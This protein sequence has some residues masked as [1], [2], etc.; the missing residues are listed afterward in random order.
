MPLIARFYRM[1]MNSERRTGDIW[2]LASHQGDENYKSSV[3][4][5]NIRIPFQNKEGLNQQ[6]TF[7]SLP[8]IKLGV[9]SVALSASSSSEMPVYFYV[10]EG[11][12]EVKDGKLV[13]NQ[14]PPKSKFPVE[15]T[16]V[17][18][19]YGRSDEPKVKTAEP[20]VKSFWIEKD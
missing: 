10:Q 18:W 7:V 19:Q 20:A 6:I 8:N 16:V 9:K 1:G 4:Q 17:A 5:F 2:L 13:L 15:V 3:Q 12:A 14:I 11:P